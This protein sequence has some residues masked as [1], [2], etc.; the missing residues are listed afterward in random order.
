MPRIKVYLKS[1]DPQT[2][3]AS[4]SSSTSLWAVV[5]ASRSGVDIAQA[6]GQLTTDESWRQLKDRLKPAGK[7][8][9]LIP[10]LK[11]ARTPENLDLSYPEKGRESTRHPHEAL[12]QACRLAQALKKRDRT[13]L[14]QAAGYTQ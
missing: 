9:K 12:R 5:L 4:H 8:G 6:V 10:R 11:A 2:S 3:Q 7:K 14:A 13:A 1:E